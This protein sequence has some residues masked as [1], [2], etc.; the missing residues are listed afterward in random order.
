MHKH[1]MDVI[2][3]FAKGKHCIE[4]SIKR[5]T[6]YKLAS[7]NILLYNAFATDFLADWFFL[8]NFDW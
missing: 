3:I 2:E 5:E 1:F 4:T 8:T 6:L 7:I